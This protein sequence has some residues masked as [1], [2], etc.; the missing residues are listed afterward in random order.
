MAVSLW[1][2]TPPLRA[3]EDR[4]GEADWLSDSATGLR[5]SAL[6]GSASDRLSISGGSDDSAKADRR[7]LL[8]ASEGAYTA[9]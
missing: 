2:E 5:A 3:G 8:R 7:C 6:T 9:F 1:R 4:S